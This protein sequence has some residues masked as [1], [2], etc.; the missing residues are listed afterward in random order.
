MRKRIAKKIFR[1]HLRGVSV[2]NS[3]GQIQRAFQRLGQEAPKFAQPTGEV[4]ESVQDTRKQT[5]ETLA[6]VRATLD[7]A[8]MKRDELRVLAKQ[9]GL[10]GYSSMKKADLIS[11]LQ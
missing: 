5:Q 6:A 9:R 10:T 1:N 2:K 8:K 4:L 7:L 3:W 11:A